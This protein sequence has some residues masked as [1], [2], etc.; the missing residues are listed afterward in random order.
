MIDFV[1]Q[2]VMLLNNKIQESLE[3]TEASENFKSL[4]GELEHVSQLYL[5]ISGIIKLFEK[6]FGP[7]IVVLQ[8]AALIIGVNQVKLFFFSF[9]HKI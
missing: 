3:L 5:E 2:L 6:S 4:E 7:I 1:R 8:C 9:L